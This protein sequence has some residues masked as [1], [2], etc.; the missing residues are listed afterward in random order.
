M[1]FMSLSASVGISLSSSLSN[2]HLGEDLVAQQRA[3]AQFSPNLFQFFIGRNSER[4]W[5]HRAHRIQICCFLYRP[6]LFGVF[7]CA[8][9]GKLKE[10][11]LRSQYQKRSFFGSENNGKVSLVL[12]TSGTFLA[13]QIDFWVKNMKIILNIRNFPV[14]EIWR[15]SGKKLEEVNQCSRWISKEHEKF[16]QNILIYFQ[17]QVLVI[18]K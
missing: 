10:K 4:I 5:S 7:K 12:C 13:C 17:H 2:I 14:A 9:C 15:C 1:R 11:R 18:K 6:T 8:T 3:R 16:C